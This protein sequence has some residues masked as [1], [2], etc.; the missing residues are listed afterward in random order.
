MPELSYLSSA[1][2]GKDAVRVFRVVRDGSTHTVVEYNVKVL[3]EGDIEISYTEADNSVVV[4]TDS[5]KNI[6][7]Y[8]AK[9]SPHILVPERFALHLGLHIVSK[10]AHI[11]KAFV[12]IEQLRWS[13]IFVGKDGKPHPYSFMRDGDEKRIVKAE[14][15]G[16]AGK[17]KILGR[18][19]G[20]INDLL[21]LKSSG[22]S[23]T[24]FIRDEYTLLK[25]VDDRIFSTSVDLS[26]TFAPISIP[27]P[28]DEKKLDFVAPALDQAEPGSVWDPSVLER[29]RTATLEIFATD[30]S[31]SVQATLYKM[32]Q[33][34]IEENA[35]VQ[36]V[37]YE[38]PN[39]HYIPVDMSY[40]GLD[41][42]TPAKAEV[43][44]P[45]AAPSGLITATVSRK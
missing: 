13:R 36:T 42:L 19:S 32:G 35:G 21:V 6:T 9:V 25:E 20:G 5:M 31:A 12:D 22:S 28:K 16:S 7:Y 17:H 40:I 10:Y 34:I 33:R 41:N 14:I 29:A 38:L 37:S 26:Y 44:Q 27:P 24:S 4:A 8:L 39:K 45:V 11:H 15:D 3:L 1:R 18:I 43:F 23:F 2:Y 30:E